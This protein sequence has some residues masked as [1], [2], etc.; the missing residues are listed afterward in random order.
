M[1]AWLLQR[2]AKLIS[3]W[4]GM[5]PIFLDEIMGFGGGWLRTAS[6]TCAG[7]VRA[8]CEVGLLGPPRTAKRRQASLLEDSFEK[9]SR[10]RLQRVQALCLGISQSYAGSNGRRMVKVVS[11]PGVLVRRMVPPWASTARLTM[12]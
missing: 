9:C 1:L 12:E 5:T 6:P 8:K 4:Q 7:H 10:S 11:M 3:S 2:F